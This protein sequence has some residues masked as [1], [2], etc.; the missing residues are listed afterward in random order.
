MSE[1]MWTSESI[2]QKL[3]NEAIAIILNDLVKL[4]HGEWLDPETQTAVQ[5]LW[6]TPVF[7]KNIMYWIL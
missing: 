4:G 7:M 2:E 6:R 5:F 3:S 1:N